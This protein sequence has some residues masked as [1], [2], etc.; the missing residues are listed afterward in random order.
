RNPPEATQRRKRLYTASQ[1]PNSEGK[2]RHGM[3][4][5][6]R[7][8]SPSKKSR[9]ASVGGWPPLCRLA[10]CTNGSN[11][12]QRSSVS[13]YRMPAPPSQGMKS[14]QDVTPVDLA[15]STRPRRAYQTTTH[16]QPLATYHSPF[17]SWANL[18]GGAEGA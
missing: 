12:A 6:I 14:P 13:M 2:S 18:A 16:D 3:P 9:S 8:N 10:W 7:Y 17:P 15:T 1:L 5:R 4:V 11:A